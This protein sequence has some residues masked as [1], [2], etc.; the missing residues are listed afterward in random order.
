MTE[1]PSPT[2]PQPR[3]HG[4]LWIVGLGLISLTI[5]GVWASQ[6]DIDQ[7]ARAQGQVIATARTQVIQSANDGL[8]EAVLVH[9]GERVTRGQRLARLDRSQAEAAWR[10]SQ[11]KVAALKAALTRLESEVYKRP[12]RFPSELQSHPAFVQNQT[13]LY[14]R[15]QAALREEV[16]AFEEGLA[17]VREEL[18]LS[19][20][21]LASGDMGRTE[22]L[23]LQKQVA[24]LQG[25]ITNRRNKYF[26]DAQAE[27]TKAEEDLSTQQ[28]VLAERTAVLERTEILA[29]TDGLVNKIHLTTLGAKVRPGDVIMEL[30]PTGGAMV[31]EAKLRPADIAWVR[32]GLPAAVKLDAYDYSVYGVLR[33]R[34][35]YISP[36][37]LSERTAQG[38]AIFYRVQIE[39]DSDALQA[40]NQV[41]PSKP[42][43]I[44]PGMTSTVE[45]VTG[46]QTVLAYLTKPVTKT[47][48]DS[49]G[50]R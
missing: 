22:V 15:R 18:T 42:I 23:R 39:I 13:E 33:G 16:A 12:L 32:A 40:R 11:G 31:I 25:Q 5:L 38:E 14:Q 27:L 34:V 49:L 7:I 8:I 30:L 17:L 4:S 35:R 48:S 45:I 43:E 1:V 20:S 46:T 28:Q 44:Q 2:L 50:E 3:L 36:D 47:L 9:E 19:Q 21:L 24:D 29:P 10:D 6:S 37:A 41:Q 26:Q